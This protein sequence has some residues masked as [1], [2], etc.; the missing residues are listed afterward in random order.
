MSFN[1]EKF[2]VPGHESGKGIEK[3]VCRYFSKK[4]KYRQLI[5]YSASPF[6]TISKEK[7]FI[8]NGLTY[9]WKAYSGL[10][11]ISL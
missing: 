5:S 4:T 10:A 8:Q 7:V 9:Q 2:R 11:H 3:K 6:S 1:Q